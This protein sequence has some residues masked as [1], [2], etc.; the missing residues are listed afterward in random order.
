[1][2]SSD[3]LATLMATEPPPTTKCSTGMDTTCASASVAAPPPA[4]SGVGTL[5]PAQ[6]CLRSPPICPMAVS[7]SVICSAMPRAESL[8]C[9]KVAPPAG[10]ATAVIA[11]GTF[12]IASSPANAPFLRTDREDARHDL[13]DVGAQDSQ[14]SGCN[15]AGPATCVTIDHLIES[16]PRSCT[17]ARLTC[18]TAHESSSILSSA[19]RSCHLLALRQLHVQ[20]RWDDR[21]RHASAAR[22]ICGRRGGRQ[23]N[24]ASCSRGCRESSR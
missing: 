14:D 8:R 4:W 1:M 6:S 12:V 17:V 9:V 16:V 13:L 20:S 24:T 22:G 5:P 19:P 18:T 7:M 2:F 11:T 15:T 3:S 10:L 23:P 21:R